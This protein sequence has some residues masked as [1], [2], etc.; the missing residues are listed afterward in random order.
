M[1][2]TSKNE[3]YETIIFKYISR[4]VLAYEILC[5][6]RTTIIDI[7]LGQPSNF[8]SKDYEHATDISPCDGWTG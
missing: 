2:Y 4:T 6:L 3:I 8:T 7:L 1:A 5:F